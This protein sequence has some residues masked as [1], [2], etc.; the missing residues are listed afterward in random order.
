MKKIL[1]T[2]ASG[3]L[4]SCIAAHPAAKQ[5]GLVFLNRSQA[6]LTDAKA[7]TQ[8]LTSH[9]PDVIINTAAYTAVDQAETEKTLAMQV[10]A[11]GPKILA[12]Y[13]RAQGARLI[14]LSTDY[15]FNGKASS[16][17]TE[18][19]AVNPINHYGE[20]KAAGEANIRNTLENHL[21]LRV[22]GVFSE[23]GKN[24]LK[25]MLTLATTQETL[26]VVDDQITCPTDAHDI[27]DTLFKILAKENRQGTY[28]YCSTPPVD[29]F[30]FAAAI[31]GS[32]ISEHNAKFTLHTMKRITTDHYPRPA[33]RPLYSVLNCEKIQ[34]E[35]GIV[36]PSWQSGIERVLAILMKETA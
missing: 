22:S 19:A 11:H 27:A 18:D 1:V 29:W 30:H 32:A 12:D 25:T 20:S 28:H 5:G 15:V 21:I 13:C 16:P 26:A 9:Q 34:A 6:N 2:G 14:H 31:F 4:A 17:Y 7:L 36:P 3:Q 23:F 8:T 33:K 35:L 24:F 10:N